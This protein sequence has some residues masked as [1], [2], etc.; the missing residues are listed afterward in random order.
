LKAKTAAAEQS[1]AAVFALF[2]GRAG[3]WGR[4]PLKIISAVLDA[5]KARG[6]N[7]ASSSLTFRLLFLERGK[8]KDRQPGG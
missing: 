8:G 6:G 4:I 3:I 1:A 5:A 2:Y 7:M